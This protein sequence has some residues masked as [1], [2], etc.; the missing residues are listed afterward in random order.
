MR[1]LVAPMIY[2]LLLLMAPPSKA[3]GDVIL[4]GPLMPGGLITGKTQPGSLI[5]LNGKA[6]RVAAGGTFL[7]GFGR[8]AKPA[9]TLEIRAPNG[10]SYTRDLQ[11]QP[12]SYQITRI[13]GLAERKVTP[14]PEDSKRIQQDNAGIGRVRRLDS[15]ME[16][17]L[18]GFQWPAS[19]R[20]SGVFGSQRV[21]NGKPRSPHNGVD[22]AAPAGAP[23]HAA[24]AG[25]VALVHPDMFYSGKTVM[26]D[27]GHGLSSVYIHMRK[28][29]VKP[30]QR[31]N[32]GDK[33]GEVGMTGRATGPHL[34]WGI[35]LFTTHL[36]PML[37]VAG[38]TGIE[39][40][41]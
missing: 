20:I 4:S 11:L 16:D 19:G 28:I 22:I 24:A 6:V 30:G 37:V 38:K 23:V 33:I 21:L 15:H 41:E 8:D 1:W 17:F 31:V 10:F 5:T 29:V 36:D 32:K 13:D 12:R 3:A 18:S 40:A 9:Q 26:I 2:G 27:H 14:K 25:S 34:H 39:V 35:S 7:L